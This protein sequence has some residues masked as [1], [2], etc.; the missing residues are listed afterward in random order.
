MRI[1]QREI[2]SALIISKDNRVLLGKQR[3]GGVYPGC[4]HIPGGGVDENETKEEALIREIKE[5]TG[6]NITNSAIKLLTDTDTDSAQKTDKN[7]GENFIAE[8]KFN[9]YQVNIPIKSY[10]VEVL[11]NDDLVEY[12]WVDVADLKNYRHTPPSIKLFHKLG[13]I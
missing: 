13:Y 6:I 5:E 11:L 7:T 12:R 1:V 4:W 9:T 3:K 10:Q 2:V 8:M